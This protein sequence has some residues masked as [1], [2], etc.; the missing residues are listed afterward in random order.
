[1]PRF[2]FD[3]NRRGILLRDDDGTELPDEGAARAHAKDVARELL[4]NNEWRARNW[5]LQIRDSAGA[6]CSELFFSSLDDSLA[7][8]TPE[9]RSSIDALCR[10]TAYLSDAISSVQ[11]TLEDVRETLASAAGLASGQSA[12][13][14]THVGEVETLRQTPTPSPPFARRMGE[15]SCSAV[16]GYRY[17]PIL[18]GSAS[19]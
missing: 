19:C 15:G 5:R 9:L 2:F 4:R 6:H 17:T 16:E 8:L 12:V 11:T 10:G 14:Y 1:M 13:P 18:G 3:L 7:H